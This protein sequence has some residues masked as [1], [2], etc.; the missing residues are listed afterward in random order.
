MYLSDRRPV[1]GSDGSSFVVPW[2]W[3]PIPPFLFPHPDFPPATDDD[4]NLFCP[5]AFNA[6]KYGFEFRNSYMAASSRNSI[7][8]RYRN[9]D[10]TYL[11]GQDDNYDHGSMATNCEANVQ[12]SQR[13][14]RATNY[15]A[16]LDRFYAPHNHDLV[17]VPGV[18]HS[19]R[20]YTEPS[21]LEVLFR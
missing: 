8:S 15:L 20:V 7:R 4:D 17:E 14:E 10:V 2:V 12:G 11:M 9:R 19:T 6:Y 3:G 18:N 16:Y 21:G 1:P 13:L 5:L